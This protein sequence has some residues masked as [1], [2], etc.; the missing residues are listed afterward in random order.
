MVDVN[1]LKAE[2]VRNGYSQKS[3]AKE[4]GMCSKTLGLKMQN[5]T[6]GCDEVENLIKILNLSD[7]MSIFF[8]NQVT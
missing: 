6:F 8:A 3:L 2:M 7:P 1:A 4:L 5:G